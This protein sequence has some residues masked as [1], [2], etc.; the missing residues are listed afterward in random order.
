MSVHGINTFTPFPR[1]ENAVFIGDSAI[2]ALTELRIYGKAL[3]GGELPNMQYF[4][5]AE[6]LLECTSCVMNDQKVLTTAIRRG[7]IDYILLENNPQS[8]INPAEL[9]PKLEAEGYAVKILDITEDPVTNLQNAASIFHE[10]KRGE[11]VVREFLRLEKMLNE[12]PA[13]P[14]QKILTL[15]S[16]RH[17]IDDRIF[18]FALSD[19]SEVSRVIY[20]ELSAVNPVKEHLF[21]TVIPGLVE[22]KD[23]AP[24]LGQ[25]PDWIAVTGDT[26]GVQKALYDFVS[27]HPERVPTVI[28]QMKVFSVPYYG[29]PLAVRR[30][31]ILSR[32][33]QAAAAAI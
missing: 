23:L 18:L 24:F 13:L 4:H 6:K 7:E 17:P 27:K 10:E 1:Y 16:I 33:R 26:L 22:I 30:P 28:Q 11:R 5:P 31:S 9:A 2:E 15:M 25:N 3:I 21:E 32:W 19:A 29:K 20:P 14:V 8:D 12:Q